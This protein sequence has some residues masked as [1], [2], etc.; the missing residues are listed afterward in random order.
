MKSQP[1]DEGVIRRSDE[2]VHSSCEIL[3]LNEMRTRTLDAIGL[4]LCEAVHLAGPGVDARRE[5]FLTLSDPFLGPT[6]RE[7]LTTHCHAVSRAA[8]RLGEL[9]GWPENRLEELRMAGLLHDIGKCA[10]PEA[11]L[12]K[13][14]SLS[15]LEKEHISGHSRLGAQIARCMGADAPVQAMIRYHHRRY[16]KD[17]WLED[18]RVVR[19]ADII[20]VADALVSMLSCRPYSPARPAKEVVDELARCAGTQFH[21]AVVALTRGATVDALAA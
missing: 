21:P 17:A 6:Q 3:G 18:A 20:C 5:A 19:G 10:I 12:A 13:P 14:A 9:V 15:T 7:H 1:H 8:V 11:L 4:A 16:G 2:L